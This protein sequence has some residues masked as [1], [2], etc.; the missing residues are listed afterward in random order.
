VRWKLRDDVVRQVVV[1]VH[2]AGCT[3]NALSIK[4]AHHPDQVFDP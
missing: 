4:F 3:D 1:V 2:P